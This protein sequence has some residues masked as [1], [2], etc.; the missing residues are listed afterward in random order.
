MT[1]EKSNNGQ[2]VL[3][4]PGGHRLQASLDATGTYANVSQVLSPNVWTN[5]DKGAFLSP[6]TNTSTASNRFFRLLD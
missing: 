2:V 4:W 6:W 1:A 5:I 3:H